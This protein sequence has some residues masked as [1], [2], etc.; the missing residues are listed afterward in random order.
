MQ[1]VH[2]NFIFKYI[3]ASKQEPLCRT[4]KLVTTAHKQKK[5]LSLQFGCAFSTNRH[6][7]RRIRTYIGI[8]M[9]FGEY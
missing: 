2:Y 5:L 1:T 9:K 8:A 3:D 7:F 6:T 4:C